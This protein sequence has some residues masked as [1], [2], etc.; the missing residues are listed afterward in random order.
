MLEIKC[1]SDFNHQVTNWRSDSASPFHHIRKSENRL[2]KMPF[3]IEQENCQLGQLNSYLVDSIS[4]FQSNA[5][6]FSN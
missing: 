4:S 6:R 2:S 1:N 3:I 5:L